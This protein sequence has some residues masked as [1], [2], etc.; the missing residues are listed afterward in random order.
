MNE[1]QIVTCGGID[2][3]VCSVLSM[4]STIF[5]YL[6][7]ISAVLAVLLII[8]AG[9]L[10]LLGRGDE[11]KQ[12][13]AKRALIFAVFG[14]A[15]TLVSFLVVLSIYVFSGA[16]NTNGWYKVDCSSDA[17]NAPSSQPPENIEDT[18]YLENKEGQI[19]DSGSVASIVTGDKKIVKLDPNEV[20]PTSMA[21]DIKSLDP[22]KT[23][24]FVAVQKDTPASDIID[25][26]NIDAGFEK[27]KAAQYQ[28]QKQPD[29]SDKF[30]DPK[31]KIKP[32]FSVKTSDADDQYVVSGGNDVQRVLGQPLLFTDKQ[33]LEAVTT[34][35]KKVA[36]VSES[37]DKNVYAYVTG[38]PSVKGSRDESCIDSGGE[39]IEF[40]NSCMADKERYIN[41]NV[42]CSNVYVPVTGC[43]CP[44][45]YYL[46]GEK[47][48]KAKEFEKPEPVVTCKDVA[49]ETHQCSSRCEGDIMMNYPESIQ[50]ECLDTLNGPQVNKRYCVGTPS[51]SNTENQ[52]CANQFNSFS[53]QKKQQMAEDFYNKN[54]QSPDWYDKILED[55]FGKGSDVQQNQNKSGSSGTSGNSSSSGTGNTGTGNTG[56]GNTSDNGTGT[57]GGTD[58][59]KTPDTGT[60]PPDQGAGNF[61][62]TPNFQELKECIGLKGEQIP[63][64]GILVVLLNPANFDQSDTKLVNNHN[65]NISR[66]FYLARDGKLIGKNGEDLGKTPMAGG[67]EYG[68]RDFSKGTSNNSMWGRGW[69]IFKGPTTYNKGGWT[70]KCSYGSHDGYKI[71]GYTRNDQNNLGGGTSVDKKGRTKEDVLSMGRCGQH[72]GKKGSSAGCATMGNNSRCGFI[73]KS[74][75]YMTKSNGTIMQ[76]NLKGEM[77]PVSGKFKS[78]DCGKIDYCAAKKSFQNSNAR[79]FRND[80]NEGYEANDKRK[81]DC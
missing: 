37:G 47:C 40:S 75:E 44:S 64:N 21:N 16:K 61:N 18:S 69:K 58:T 34:G 30:V 23:I 27:D 31:G 45:G 66:M 59:G 50:D 20:D 46:D 22:D 39:I 28:V 79:S 11:E 65:E 1:E 72:V 26:R 9:F 80:P 6:L 51:N 48:I 35:L 25:F 68:A 55:V 5:H 8:I 73:N 77:D 53:E 2:C 33:G 71:G 60:V 3:T 67:Q 12:S 14:F 49:M 36:Q 15:F 29:V 42:Q 24:N 62:P 38:S 81:V 74:K 54:K 10:Y 56:A 52:K 17:A 32:L 13:Q 63:Y 78:P 19:F 57:T 41:R 4:V 70:D 7:D 76:I 43:K